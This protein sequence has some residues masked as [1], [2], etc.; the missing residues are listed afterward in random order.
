[1]EILERRGKEREKRLERTV[2]RLAQDR[3]KRERKYHPERNRTAAEIKEESRAKLEQK[4][5][6]KRD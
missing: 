1:M 3:L 4:G 5:F 2:E 6:F